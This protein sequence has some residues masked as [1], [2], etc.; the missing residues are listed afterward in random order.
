MTDLHPGMKIK[1][2]PVYVVIPD[3]PPRPDLLPADLP[4][5]PAKDDEVY[6]V[7]QLGRTSI[8]ICA[9]CLDVPYAKILRYR[10]ETGDLI[11][12]AGVG[13]KKDIVGQALT[14]ATMNSPV[15]K[16]F[17][18]GEPVSAARAA[19]IGLVNSVV[20]PGVLDAHAQR[21]ASV[22]ASRSPSG[23][24]TAKRLI[25]RGLEVPLAD[26]L[27]LEP[28]VAAGIQRPDQAAG[29]GADDDVRNDALGFQ[30]LDLLVRT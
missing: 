20:A 15:G 12:Q 1:I 9:E 29:T 23:A 16:A 13:W 19:E 3:G 14:R 6:T 26:A 2:T 25:H 5:P 11:V 4:W 17:L 24:R 22:L 28:V 7:Y 27:Q 8:G 21:L 30:H 10:R 18:T